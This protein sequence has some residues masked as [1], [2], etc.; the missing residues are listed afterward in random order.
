[1]NA[2]IF[3]IANTLLIIALHYWLQRLTGNTY[4]IKLSIR[5]LVIDLSEIVTLL[6]LKE[7]RKTSVE[8]HEAL[9]KFRQ[10]IDSQLETLQTSHAENER[11]RLEFTADPETGLRVQK[12]NVDDTCIDQAN[13]YKECLRSLHPSKSLVAAV[14]VPL[15]K[16]KL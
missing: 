10:R 15:E 2:G 9:S 8:W 7:H 14:A 5:E 16:E 6:D 13:I 1:M 11:R 3:V 12:Q 4:E